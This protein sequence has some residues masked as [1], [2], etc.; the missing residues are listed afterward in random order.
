MINSCKRPI[1]SKPIVAAKAP[2]RHVCSVKFLRRFLMSKS[3]TTGAPDVYHQEVKFTSAW[4]I[5]S[6]ALILEVK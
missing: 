5:K 3:L 6:V 1:D 4:V 2:Q